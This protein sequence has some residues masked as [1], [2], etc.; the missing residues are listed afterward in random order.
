M[1]YFGFLV[2]QWGAAKTFEVDGAFHVGGF[3][4]R[5]FSLGHLSQ[6]ITKY[7]TKVI[8]LDCLLELLWLFAYRKQGPQ[9]PKYSWDFVEEEEVPEWYP[10][11]E[12]IR[13][14]QAEKQLREQQ[15]PVN[16][17]SRKTSVSSTF[18]RKMSEQE[19]R[20]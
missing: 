5:K 6:L 2:F 9:P 17:H 12:R 20:N 10:D 4:L 1:H 19:N 18:I 15:E 14:E 8:C 3:S 7:L 11:P 13:R 16:N